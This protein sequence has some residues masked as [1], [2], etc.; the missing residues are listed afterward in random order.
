MGLRSEIKPC[1]DFRC[2]FGRGHV[3][4]LEEEMDLMTRLQPLLSSL[5]LESEVEFVRGAN[6][7]EGRILNAEAK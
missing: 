4:V 6:V 1:L 5:L 3:P 7:S 2:A